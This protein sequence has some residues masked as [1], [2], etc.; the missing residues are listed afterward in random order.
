MVATSDIATTIS[1]RISNL[2]SA[3]A[4]GNNI[5]NMVEDA[6]VDVQNALTVSIDNSNVP[7]QYQSVIRNQG[8]VYALLSAHQAAPDFNTKAGDVDIRIADGKSRTISQLEWYQKQVEEDLK[9]LRFKD[10]AW[11]QTFY[12]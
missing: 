12:K 8:I 7:E 5:L 4:S 1:E 10:V 3:V 11:G 2:P 6:R 9:Q